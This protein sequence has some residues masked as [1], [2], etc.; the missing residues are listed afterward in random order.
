MASKTTAQETG[1]RLAKIETSLD[2]LKNQADTTV[3][4]LDQFITAA[5]NKYATKEEVA[6][7]RQNLDKTETRFW[8]IV[9]DWAPIIGVAAII[10][11]QLV[12]R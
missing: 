7:V 2:Y 4:K 9:K 8:D 3:Q 12:T 6:L 1:E 5:D 11:I 10:L